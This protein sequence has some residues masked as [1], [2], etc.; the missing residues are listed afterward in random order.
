MERHGGPDTC[1][2]QEILITPS[3]LFRDLCSCSE[4]HFANV[5]HFFDFLS[6]LLL[7][8]LLLHYPASY[9][10]LSRTAECTGHH[11]LCHACHSNGNK[12]LAVLCSFPVS[13]TSDGDGDRQRN[14]QTNKAFFLEKIWTDT[15][16]LWK[17]ERVILNDQGVQDGTW[18]L[19]LTIIALKDKIDEFGLSLNPQPWH[20]SETL[21]TGF[22]G[23]SV[24]LRS[25]RS[26]LLTFSQ[27]LSPLKLCNQQ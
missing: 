10:C 25:G 12:D 5:L 18:W 1:C 16:Q 19:P 24:L 15:Q 27:T 20:N 9:C 26:L 14:K 6:P 2:S 22:V 3:L 17:V 11:D 4:K 13:K 8:L 21:S 7:S 23:S